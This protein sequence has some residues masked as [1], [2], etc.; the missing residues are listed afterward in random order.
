M[1]QTKT[2]I[3]TV[4]IDILDNEPVY[5]GHCLLITAS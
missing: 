4:T 1:N 5:G 2:P 3:W